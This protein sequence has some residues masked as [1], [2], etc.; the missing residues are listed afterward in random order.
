M[1]NKYWLGPGSLSGGDRKANIQPDEEIPKKVLK[2]MSDKRIK[3]FEEAGQI[4]DAP[5]SAAYIIAGRNT[6]KALKL[7]EKDKTE[8][9]KKLEAAEKK[10][11]ELEAENDKLKAENKS[12]KGLE[13]NSKSKNVLLEKLHKAY[14]DLKKINA[15]L[16]K[17]LQSKNGLLEKLGK[18]YEDLRK[19]YGELEKSV[20]AGELTKLTKFQKLTNIL[21]Y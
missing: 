6:Q 8:L 2:L 19:E 17:N 11:E 20:K 15:E 12:F 1:A 3:K 16:E 7:S 4:G 13:K 14:E 21:K 10:I 18:V 9:V 5:K